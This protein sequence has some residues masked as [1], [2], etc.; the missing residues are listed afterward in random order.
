MKKITLAHG[1]GGKLTK[2]LVN[3]IIIKHLGNPALNKLDDS[4]II[5][6]EKGNLAF[7]TD[8]YVVDP[9]FFPGGDIG[10]LAV[11][12]TI[13]DLA[14]CGAKP[15]FISLSLIIEEGFSLVHLEKIIRSVKKAAKENSVKVVCGDIKVVDRGHA[16][17]IFINT[18]GIGKV[19]AKDDISSSKVKAGDKIIVSGSI[20]DHGVA[21]LTARKN[22]K[23]Y[24]KLK[25]D[26][27]PLAK[28]VQKML[29]ASNKIHAMRDPTRGGLATVL[30][31]IA[32]A[33]KI[34]IKI[35]ESLIPIT[36][37]TKAA[38]EILGFDPLYL[39]CEGRL[40][41]F[42]H[43]QDADKVLKKMK[44]DPI[45]KNS[46]IIGKVTK[47]HPGKVIMETVSGGKRIVDTFSGEQ[48]P[49]IC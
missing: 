14:M 40:I 26:C 13:N 29:R 21:V 17:K 49:R 41:A 2:E 34:G 47:E 44:A 24:T 7:T 25:S 39:A 27:A 6:G 36:K 42:V 48:L 22:L 10:K 19:I 12:G 9:I 15:F 30:N 43:A 4:A 18:T 8:S 46:Q 45:G 20:G 32:E 37:E 1:G 16:D 11:S 3:K 35:E 28:I 31:E 33:S 5:A 38:C 23:L